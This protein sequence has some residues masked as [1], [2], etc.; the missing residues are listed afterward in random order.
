[1]AFF[2]GA[3]SIRLRADGTLAGGIEHVWK[4]ERVRWRFGHL[5]EIMSMNR[6]NIQPGRRRSYTPGTGASMFHFVCT[7][8]PSDPLRYSMKTITK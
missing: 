7:Y 1:M 8:S 3:V 4:A 2:P 6:E 5:T